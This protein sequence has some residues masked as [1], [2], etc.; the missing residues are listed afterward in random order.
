MDISLV[1]FMFLVSSNASR[2]YISIS[3]RR[4]YIW[5]FPWSNSQTI[6]FPSSSPDLDSFIGIMNMDL[7]ASL[8]RLLR[9]YKF[10]I[11]VFGV[12]P[13]MVSPIFLGHKI[14]VKVVG[15]CI[16]FHNTFI[17]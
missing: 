17:G 5:I 10:L 7:S 6:S 13:F 2:I 3:V 12:K 11:C 1:S 8:N 9:T 16:Q 14:W 15:F 4:L